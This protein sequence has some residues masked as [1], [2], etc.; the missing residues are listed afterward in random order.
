MSTD[1]V[2]SVNRLTE[3]QNLSN[4]LNPGKGTTSAIDSDTEEMELSNDLNYSKRKRQLPDED[5]FGHPDKNKTGREGQ[6]NLQKGPELKLSNPFDV[7]REET[8]QPGPS[9]E[10]SP[11]QQPKGCRLL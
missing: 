6:L 8:S 11:P 7:L 10:A 9:K 4:P 3:G 5:S 2:C 1:S